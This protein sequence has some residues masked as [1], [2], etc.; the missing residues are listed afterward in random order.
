MHAVVLVAVRFPAPPLCCSGGSGRRQQRQQQHPPDRVPHL[1]RHRREARRQATERPPPRPRR[2]LPRSRHEPFGCVS[3][4]EQEGGI[5]GS[6]GGMAAAN[7]LAALPDRTAAAAA[8]A[9]RAVADWQQCVRSNKYQRRIAVAHG[10][11]I[12][13]AP[14]AGARVAATGGSDGQR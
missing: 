14:R 6:S 4:L 3:L 1:S 12:A 8:A 13:I 11:G 7:P 10:A 9:A 5:D 2:R